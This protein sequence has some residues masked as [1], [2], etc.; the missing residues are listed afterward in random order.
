MAAADLRISDVLA[1]ASA[2]DTAELATLERRA[3]R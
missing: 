3:N 1:A 2:G